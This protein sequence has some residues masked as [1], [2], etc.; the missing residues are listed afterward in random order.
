MSAVSAPSKSFLLSRMSARFSSTPGVSGSSA[1]ARVSAAS[2][3]SCLPSISSAC[4]RRAMASAL[5]GSSSR[6]ASRSRS[7]CAGSPASQCTTAMRSSTSPFQGS[8]SAH[9]RSQL[10]ARAYSPACIHSSSRFSGSGSNASL[11][12]ITPPAPAP[13]P[14]ILSRH[15][16]CHLPSPLDLAD[17][18]VVMLPS[19]ARP[20]PCGRRSR[21]RDRRPRQCPCRRPVNSPL[22]RRN[23]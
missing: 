15:H 13:C 18:R 6:K 21:Y 2:A 16:Y 5:S 12:M 14:A 23:A 11:Y 1:S 7:V 22:W 20:S 3:S 10:S 17:D 9:S 8:R 4:A 19:H